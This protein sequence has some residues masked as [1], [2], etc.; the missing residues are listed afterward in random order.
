MF[1]CWERTVFIQI[2]SLTFSYNRIS[3][4]T[5]VSL[6]SVGQFRIQLLLGDNT[7]SARYKKPKI[8]RYSKTSTEWTLVSLYFT[9]KNHVYK[10]IHDQI[11]TLRADMCFNIITKTHSV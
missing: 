2:I 1:V 5:N 4:L 9:E 6:K 11:D 7:R 3:I 10:I 8:D